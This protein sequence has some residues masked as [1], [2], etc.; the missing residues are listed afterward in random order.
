[1]RTHPIALLP[2]R[3]EYIPL[4]LIDLHP[5]ARQHSQ[6]GIASLQKSMSQK[7]Q[8]QNIVVCPSKDG[9]YEV[10]AGAGRVSQALS[11]K[12]EKIY[13]SIREG[14]TEVQKLQVMLSEN[15]AREAENPIHKG[16]VY[17]AMMD[18]GKLTQEELAKEEEIS[19]QT[20]QEYVSL[21]GL[22][23]ALRENTARAVNLG[24]KHYLQ[25]LR[26]KTP[27][28]RVEMAEKAEKEELTVKELTAEVNKR[29]GKK[30]ANPPSSP[31]P[32]RGKKGDFAVPDPL[33]DFWPGVRMADMG[34]WKVDFGTQRF[35]GGKGP[36]LPSWTIH[37]ARNGSGD[38]A[39]LGQWFRKMAEAIDPAE[40]QHPSPRP[41]KGE[42]CAERL[43]RDGSPVVPVGQEAAK[44]YRIGRAFGI[45]PASEAYDPSSH[46]HGADARIPATPQ[47]RAELEAL[48]PQ[49]PAAVYRWF[50]GP[51]S[52]S[53]AWLEGM[54][55]ADLQ[56]PSD[57]RGAINRVLACIEGD[58]KSD[59]IINSK[60]A[61]QPKPQPSAPAEPPLD[62]ELA[63]MLE[64]RLAKRRLP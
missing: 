35:G 58:R 1:M 45:H 42:G 17:Q 21:R 20:L 2:S 6:K 48:V 46:D 36:Q 57:A 61:S 23:E 44:K 59:A 4:N 12:W 29:L 16:M 18:A 64:R 5:L 60:K 11:G 62:P 15:D 50:F 53:A 19:Q 41:L 39:Y 55:W 9:R 43:V 3:F 28:E 38:K 31:F 30:A 52:R 24:L 32:K 25:I 54:T 51:K 34:F 40:K 33:A 13:C 27:E 14:L 49:G 63:A 10:I 22:P 26:L 7:G 47:D 56:F 37:V 8:L